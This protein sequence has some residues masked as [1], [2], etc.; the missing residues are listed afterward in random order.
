MVVEIEINFDV[1]PN[2]VIQLVAAVLEGSHAAFNQQVFPR[3]LRPTDPNP[4]I[5]VFPTLWAPDQ[6]SLEM[7]HSP[8][9]EPTV[10]TYSIVVQAINKDSDKDIALARHSTI[11]QIVRRT[12]YRND[13]LRVQ[14]GALRVT[15]GSV[16]ERFQKCTIGTQRFMSNEVGSQFVFLS[17]LDL[18]I[19]TETR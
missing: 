19:E 18:S 6:D 7:G 13:W 1:F 9:G 5:G 15:D 12:L 2:N 8:Q 10:Q 14:L 16:Q 11:A 4:C 17:V 3:Q